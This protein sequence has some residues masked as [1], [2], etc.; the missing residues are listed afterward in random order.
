MALDALLVSDANSDPT[1]PSP[2]ILEIE[3]AEQRTLHAEVD[4]IGGS[5]G[6]H[7]VRYT[8]VM[9]RYPAGKGATYCFRRDWMKFFS[10]TYDRQSRDIHRSSKKERIGESLC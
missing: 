2:P 3:C 10:V 7:S 5:T 8:T 1:A 6:D 4:A 9:T